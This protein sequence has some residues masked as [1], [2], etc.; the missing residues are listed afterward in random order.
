MLNSFRFYFTVLFVVTASVGIAQKPAQ[1]FGIKA[2]LN[3]PGVNYVPVIN[4]TSL[5]GFHAGLLFTPPR[6]GI[7]GY[8]TE[9]VF[10]REGYHFRTSTSKGK[11]QTDYLLLPQL[12]TINL[13]PLIQLQVGGQLAFLIGGNADSTSSNPSSVPDPTGYGKVSDYFNRIKYGFVGGLEINP[14]GG[15]ILGGRYNFNMGSI[16]KQQPSGPLPPYFPK[17]GEEMKMHLIQLYIG[18][19]F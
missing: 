11:V 13:G 10:S 2:G 4:P 8:H 5:P 1:S 3:V 18:Y 7:F 9:L 15:Y 19:F 17:S 14:V 6:A 16:N 12:M